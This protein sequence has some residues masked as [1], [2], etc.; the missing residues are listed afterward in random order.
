[1]ASSVGEKFSKIGFILAVA[2]SAVGLGNAWMFPTLV[3]QNGGGA[4]IML[5]V[6]LTLLVGFVIFLAELAIGKLSG[7]D[8]TNAYYS[9]APRHKRAWSIVGFTMVGALLIVSFYSVVIGWILHYMF[10][11]FSVLPAD[12][13]AS[14]SAFTRLLEHDALGQIVCFSVIFVLVFY[15]VS[16]GIK[17]GI[18]KLNVWMM[19]ALFIILILM[20]VYSMSVG[21]FV[22][23]ASFLFHPDFSMLTTSSVLRALGLAFFS[24]SLGVGTIITYSAS[25]PDRTNFVTS[26]LNIIFINIIIGLMMGLIVFTFIFEYGADPTAQG[27]GLIFISLTTLFAKLGIFGH[28]LSF[29]FFLALLFAGIT[30]AISMIEPFCAYL[31][32]TFG[33]SRA[34]ALVI[35]GIFVYALGVACIY[36]NI[37]DTKAGLTFFG[38]GL[39][40]LLNYIASNIL[41]PF[42]G[43]MA[44]IFVGY[45]IDMR[46][47]HELFVPYMGEGGFRLWRFFLRYISPLAVI[48]IALNSFGVF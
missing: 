24:L 2:G 5:Y 48:I 44:A 23:A 41:M 7:K 34:K 16:R 11:S 17:D 30:S 27:P 9:L 45:V 15:I 33:L 8:P 29:G 14:A 42:G 1:M 13:K 31:I 28:V 43:L 22:Q 20:L 18:E 12:T 3:G 47:V 32:N 36:S 46:P 39:F 35:I 26:T 38:M 10:A 19:P 6:G 37:A 25:L 4:F 21:G 40:D